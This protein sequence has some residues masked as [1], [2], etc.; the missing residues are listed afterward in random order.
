MPSCCINQG[1]Y[2][3]TSVMEVIC[4]VL[5]HCSVHPRLARLVG[6][7]SLWRYV[8]FGRAPLN[9]QFLHKFIRFLGPHTIT[10]SVTG[11]VRGSG[12]HHPKGM[13]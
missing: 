4:T 5:V 1:R 9:L 6:D 11:F 8:D 10:I 3:I 7:L 12:R 2:Y 13:L